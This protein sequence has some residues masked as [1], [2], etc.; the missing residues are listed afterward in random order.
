ME[1]LFC[2]S[3]LVYFILWTGK[4]TYLKLSCFENFLSTFLIIAGFLKGLKN[5]TKHHLKHSLSL[6]WILANPLTELLI[7]LGNE[8]YELLLQE[9]IS[10][11]IR[12]CRNIT[13]RV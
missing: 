3:I 11:M 8:N 6:F 5:L 12:W 1:T 9:G 4:F 2:F 13:S 10:E 7:T